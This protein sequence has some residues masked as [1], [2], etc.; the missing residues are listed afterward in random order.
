MN[1]DEIFDYDEISNRIRRG[2][3]KGDEYKFEIDM[4]NY[5]RH[6]IPKATQRTV[7]LVYRRAWEEGHSYGY[8]EVLNYASDIVYFMNEILNEYSVI[9]RCD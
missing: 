7:G 9:V 5:I 6:A 2:E 8:S 3:Y 1:Y 4:R